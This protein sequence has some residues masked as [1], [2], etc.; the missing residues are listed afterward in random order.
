MTTQEAEPDNNAPFSTDVEG[1]ET[2]PSTA[3]TVEEQQAA[4]LVE[5]DLYQL[6]QRAQERDEYLTLAQRTQADFENYR[7]RMARDLGVAE[8]RGVIKLLEAILPAVDSLERALE[9]TQQLEQETEGHLVE[10][11]RLVHAEFSAALKRAGVEVYSPKGELFDPTAHEAMAQQPIEG[12]E[13]GTVAEVFERGY[14]FN[15]T[16]VRPARVVVAAP[17]PAQ[18]QTFQGETP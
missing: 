3:E 1:S 18:E 2:E 11:L 7:R 14:Q 4:D 16:I 6:R 10:G 15:E 8:E 9:T 5:E 17:P 12:V 13:P